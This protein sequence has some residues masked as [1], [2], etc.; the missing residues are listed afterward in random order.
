MKAKY[1]IQIK[2]SVSG[3]ATVEG[4]MTQKAAAVLAQDYRDTF[5]ANE[6]R[7]ISAEAFRA[8][9][10]AAFDSRKTA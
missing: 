4:A 3:W 6:T 9:K 7:V 2:A 10:R 1:L 5:R 8:E